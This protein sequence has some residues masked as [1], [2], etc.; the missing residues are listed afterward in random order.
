MQV[1]NVS[2]S[3]C[4]VK[5][6]N[7]NNCQPQNQPSFGNLF[8]PIVSFANFIETNGFLGEFLTVDTLGMATPRAVQGYNRNKK[9]LGHLNYKA[10]HEELTREAL[11]GP[12]FF[13]V[14]AGVVAL[15]ALVKGKSAK[16]TVETLDVFKGVMQN[17]T[18]DLKDLKNPKSINEKFIS[19]ITDNA[20]K[21][22]EDKDGKIEKIKNILSNVVDKKI[23]KKEARKSIEETLNALNKNNGKFLD[24]TSKIKVGDKD[25]N[26]SDLVSDIPNYLE[27]FTKQSQKSTASKADFIESFHK[28]KATVRKVTNISAITALSASLL[29]IPKLYQTDKNFPGLDG[30]DTSNPRT[31][32]HKNK[33]E[34][35]NNVQSVSFSG[36]KANSGNKAFNW[37]AEKCSLGNK[38]DLTRNMFLVI[39]SIFMMGSRFK[40][41]RGKDEKR[42]ILTRDIPGIL[43]S[44]YG[45][46]LLNRAIA[47]IIT[48]KTGVP[49]TQFVKE[50]AKTFKNTLFVH[51][52]QIKDW[53]TGFQ[54]LKNPLISFSETIEKHGGDI[55][56]AMSKL[57]FENDLKAICDKKDATNKEIIEALKKAQAANSNTFKTLENKLKEV[58]K[59]NKLFKFAQKAQA[60]VKIGGIAL[61]A[62]ILGIAIPRLN[63]VNTR[64]KYQGTKK[65]PRQ[66][67][68]ILSQN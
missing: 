54:D 12:V 53:Y 65:H 40:D 27:D 45:A 35:Q 19:N 4:N 52:K 41:A 23:S 56:K 55:K 7:R 31:K 58:P 29:A 62:A 32:K 61:T 43:L 44:V 21:D 22:F 9:E 48:R 51:Q 46:S 47:Y 11:S 63:I 10:G 38:S 17:A 1:S 42:E 3:N 36:N 57:G 18:K 28:T 68:A 59:D 67:E 24:D 66:P 16:L 14:P 25:M 39:S 30:L 15:V 20:F 49:I 50:N 6:Y 8:N 64:K 37:V 2:N 5:N 26:I 13:F 33:E 34:N 60:G